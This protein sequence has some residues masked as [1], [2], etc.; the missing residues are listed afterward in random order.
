M[1]NRGVIPTAQHHDEQWTISAVHTQADIQAHI[2]A[3]ADVA[4]EL[5]TARVA[6]GA[7]S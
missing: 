2:D 3:F 1:M 7:S 5:S 4:R 6:L